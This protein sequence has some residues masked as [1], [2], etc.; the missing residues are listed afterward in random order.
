MGRS[1]RCIH[2]YQET[3]RLKLL[4]TWLN[5]EPPFCCLCAQPETAIEDERISNHGSIK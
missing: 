3:P 5:Q 4:L 1:I 2:W